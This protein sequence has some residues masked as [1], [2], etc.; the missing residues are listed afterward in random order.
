MSSSS[1]EHV[2]E[3]MNNSVAESKP[4]ATAKEIAERFESKDN[5]SYIKSDDTVANPGGLLGNVFYEKTGKPD[6]VPFFLGVDCKADEKNILK[7]PIPRSEM[8]IDNKIGA[9]AKILSYVSLALAQN[10]VFEF[11]VIDNYA[12]RININSAEWR[13]AINYWL[14]L[15]AVKSLLADS[16]VGAV[17]VVVGI[18]QKY[19]STK[20]FKKFEGSVKGG[21]FGVNVGGELY[22]SST[23]YSLDIV[24]GLNLV[25]MPKVKTSTQLTK[26]LKDETVK[27]GSAKVMELNVKLGGAIRN[28]GIANLLGK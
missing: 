23:N 21:A 28:I 2:N 17:G 16:E 5:L 12:A 6:L 3:V 11:R 7:T 14:Q 19:I 10:E 24:Y 4:L 20:K 13:T 25:Y 15:V 18:I 27:V 22:T 9:D 8:I 1:K 26:M